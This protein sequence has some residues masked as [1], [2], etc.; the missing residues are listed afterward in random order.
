MTSDLDYQVEIFTNR[1]KKR[2]KHLGKWARK[3][4]ISCY[5]LYDRDIPEIP[6]AVDLYENYLHLAEYSAQ[7]KPI[8]GTPDEYRTAMTDAARRALGVPEGRVFYKQRRQTP[9]GDQYERISSTASLATVSEG[10]LKFRVNFSD[11]L[12]TGLFLDHRR[13]RAMMRELVAELAA[14]RPVRVLNLFSYTG[15]FTVYV[16][17]GGALRTVSVDMSNTYTDWARENLALNGL[18]I[19]RNILLAQDVFRFLEHP[20]SRSF[21]L[22]ILDPP[23]F[24]NSKKMDRILDLQRDHVELI[25]AAGKFLRRGGFLLF[26]TN[27]RKF[28]MESQ[29]L[30][31]FSVTDITSQTIPQDFRDKRIHHCWLLEKR[32]S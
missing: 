19:E 18:A 27:R 21:D 14:E 23:T 15:S 10:G 1:L 2:A 20:D 31:E 13:T 8:P 17:D 25:Q 28:T 32:T 4:D 5:R 9:R 16:A 12:D 3:N 29:S 26:S 30:G 24:S 6:L 7:H 11:Y 22:V